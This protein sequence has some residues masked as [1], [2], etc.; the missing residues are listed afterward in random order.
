LVEVLSLLTV[1]SSDMNRI[2][3]PLSGLC[4]AISIVLLYFGLKD[5]FG[6]EN[7]SKFMKMFIVVEAMYFAAK[8][9]IGFLGVR[10]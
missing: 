8:M 10:I 2:L 5:L 4:T 1:I 9:I 7:D 3:T 6:E